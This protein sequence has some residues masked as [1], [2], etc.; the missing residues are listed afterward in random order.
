MILKQNKQE[1]AIS[2]LENAKSLEPKIPETYGK[3]GEVYLQRG[4]YLL[5]EKNLRKAIELNP[6][7][8]TAIRN[9]GVVNYYH[10]GRKAD[11]LLFFARSL[12][13]DPRQAQADEIR[14]LLKKSQK[15]N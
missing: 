7:Y 1:E 11:G 13:L 14:K 6:Q 3:L 5:A 10:L 2:L 8:V 12:T 4:Q 15:S 9:L